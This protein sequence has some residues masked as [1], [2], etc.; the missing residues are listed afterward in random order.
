MLVRMSKVHIIGLKSY[1]LDVVS[2]LH[3]FGR[4]HLID[5]G[6][7]IDEGGLPIVKME[8]FPRSVALRDEL[9]ALEQRGRA[10]IKGLFGDSDILGSDCLLEQDATMGAREFA[11]YA[12]GY[13]EE[14]GP[15][16]TEVIGRYETL[17]TQLADLTKY[18]PLMEKIAPAVENLVAGRDVDSIAL[19]L[20]RR[21]RDAVGEMR[22]QLAEVSGNHTT[23]IT[24]D[25]NQEMMAAVIIVDREFAPTVR[26][27][28]AGESMTRVKL[29]GKFDSLPFAEALTEIRKTITALPA[30]IE[31]VGAEL[32][33]MAERHRLELC[34]VV[35]GLANRVEQY[36][37]I[38]NFGETEYTFLVAGYIP[39][40]DLPEL[41]A[42]VAGRWDDSVTIDD[43]PIDPH[44]YPRVPIQL[45]NKGRVKPFQTILG[46]WGKP[47][48]GSFDPSSILTISF[49]FLWGMI[50]GDAGYGLLLVV[51]CL[52]LRAK[53]KDNAAIGIATDLFLPAG[54][55]AMVFGVFYW[56]F[57]GDLLHYVP[58][59]HMEP[60]Q[61]G[62]GFSIPFIR[63]S[64]SMQTTYLLMAMGVGVV[65]VVWGLSIGVKTAG[66][67]GHSKHARMQAGILTLIFAVLVLAAISAVPSLAAGLGDGASSVI[68]YLIYLAMAVGFG[69]ALWS[70][71][72]MGAIETV[73]AFAHI[74]SY[75]RIM[76]VGLVGAYLADAANGLAF[77]TM[78]GA[79]GLII[80][81]IL[82]VLNFV[83]I[84][85]SPTIHALRLN[86][87]E[88]FNNFW[89]GGKVT[90]KPFVNTGKEGLS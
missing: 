85:F 7:D 75:I 31:A 56:E 65:Q 50:V 23:V 24:Q 51:T 90:Y 79:V 86:F 64:A 4:L 71:G 13:L 57:F 60:I 10:L 19:L 70:S 72:I 14:F 22:A 84:C 81:L 43:I 15:V 33:D 11:D 38:L 69:V 17:S 47:M 40:E 58:I 61:L 39:T 26:D 49:P 45:E 25:L 27:Y 53:Y 80:A 68:T 35:N 12:S 87:L 2:A 54:L 88:F 41:R 18:E 21:Y 77:E 55:M 76:A 66:R 89:Q 42:L 1:L 20:E 74:A 83:I 63:T 9:E 16:A 59:I 5:L 32:A 29:P 73:E 34:G 28:L 62:S 48:Y 46:V 37:A 44:E 6:D 52:L 67:L 30:Q 82:H 3:G 36:E 8:L 78:P